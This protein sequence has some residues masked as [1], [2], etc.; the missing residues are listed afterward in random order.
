MA[1]ED[2]SVIY[3][4]V[5]EDI[6][7]AV[8]KL[9]TDAA[10]KVQMV[11]AKRSTLFQSVINLKL[12][13]KAAADANKEL[14]LVTSDRVAN[15]LA[16]RIGVPVASQVGEEAK[17][18][19]AAPQ[20]SVPNDDEIDGGTLGDSPKPVTVPE[21]EPK[22][23][24]DADV[25]PIPGKETPPAKPVAVPAAAAAAA[26]AK[27]AASKRKSPVP[28]I[29]TMQK[30]ILWAVAGLAAIAGLFALNYFLT[31]AQVVLYVNG[32]QR[33]AS[34]GFTA[35]PDAAQTDAEAGILSATK[36]STTKTLNGSVQAT[37]S[38]DE[39]TRA[40]GNITVSNSYDMSDHT[41]VAGT[42]FV[43]A[44]GK[45]FRS[46]EDAQVPGATPTLVNG[47]LGFKPGSVTVSVT[48][49]ANGDQYNLGPG[50]YTIPGLPAEQ[51]AKIT[52]Q[53][54]Q[55]TGGTSKIV[56]VIT[57]GD[58]DRAKQAAVDAGKAAAMKDLAS[59]AGKGQKVLE[60][61]FQQS[62]A[63][64]TPNPEVG[65]ESPSG[66]VAVEVSYA[67]L[68][69][70]QSELADL[71]KAQAQKQV[72]PDQEVYD[73]GS[74]SLQIAAKGEPNESG[75]QQF[76]A[77]AKAFA[78][79]RVDTATLQNELKG[80][81]YGDAVEIAKTKPDVDKVEISLWPGWATSLPSV[82][83][84]IKISVKVANQ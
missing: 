50:K 1:T 33:T 43:A 46:N 82:N 48:A 9:T 83:K 62:V 22:P 49:D 20:S 76:S 75:A 15:N 4:E 68:A 47:Q 42:R 18:P 77:T 6:T 23:A 84:N 57:Q 30:R 28:N 79:A 21:P 45:V 63:K 74:G 38:K 13:K 65:A 12:L 17:V 2:N 24:P 8:D 81:K 27:P 73:D 66:T 40:K 44:D 58:I 71:T 61:S 59:K 32:S 36:V 25:M 5:D 10:G 64:A 60:P 26:Q 67:Q 34:F 51:Q 29:G 52:G 69:V 35:D 14:V 53:G 55:M 11:T 3:L 54:N 56:K 7:S 19:E 31:T 80:K 70:R 78:G 41:L 39:G 72:G 16:G 37:G